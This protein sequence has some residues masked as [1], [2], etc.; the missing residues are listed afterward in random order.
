MLTCSDDDPNAYP[1]RHKRAAEY[2]ASLVSNRR[3]SCNRVGMLSHR[4][5]FACD[6]CFIRAHV[7]CVEEPQIRGNLVAALKDHH[8]SGN[9]FLCWQDCLSATPYHGAFGRH[10]LLKRLD[11]CLGFSLLD[12]PDDRVC[13]DHSNDDHRIHPHISARPQ[14]ESAGYCSRSEQDVD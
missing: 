3:F 6:R 5:G 4:H 9:Q 14:T 12:I 8:I 2:H 11:R 13:D 1:F 10:H 7:L